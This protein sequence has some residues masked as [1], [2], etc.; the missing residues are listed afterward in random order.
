M[1]YKT[2]RALQIPI[3]GVGGIETTNDALDYIYAGA[4]AIQIG[5]ANFAS[6]RTPQEV[7]AG[8]ERHLIRNNVASP[9]DLVGIAHETVLSPNRPI[10]AV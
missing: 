5:T 4:R 8:L 7:L 2:Y 3:I 1:V 9:N 6:P 10:P